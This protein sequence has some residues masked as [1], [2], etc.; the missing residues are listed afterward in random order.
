[1]VTNG[2]EKDTEE[3]GWQMAEDGKVS[4]VFSVT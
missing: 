2:R 4:H 3:L 1:M